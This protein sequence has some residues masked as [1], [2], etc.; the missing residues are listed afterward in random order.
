MCHDVHQICLHTSKVLKIA[1]LL[2]ERCIFLVVEGKLSWAT[3]R[4]G[5]LRFI[6]CAFVYFL[7]SLKPFK[8]RSSKLFT[9]PLTEL[10]EIQ[11]MNKHGS[12][13]SYCFVGVCAILEEVIQVSKRFL[14]ALWRSWWVI[15]LLFKKSPLM[16]H[17]FLVPT[18]HWMI[19]Q[20]LIFANVR[21]W[22]EPESVVMLLKLFNWCGKLFLQK[23]PQGPN[24]LRCTKISSQCHLFFWFFLPF[25][26]PM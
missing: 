18:I 10:L 1:K 14:L 25:F 11:W 19:F 22:V 7:G 24:S 21:F 12:F 6:S 2:K 23:T 3:W 20:P 26:F 13:S 16:L 9:Y 17:V 15:N 5:C 4:H 8:T